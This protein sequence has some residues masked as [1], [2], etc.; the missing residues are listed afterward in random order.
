M[1]LR[2]LSTTDALITIDEIGTILSVNDDAFLLLGH[3]SDELMGRNIKYILEEE[4]AKDH[5]AFLARYKETRVARIVGMTRT[6]TSIHRDKSVLPLELQLAE[7]KTPD[8]SQYTARIRHL[9][10]D[11]RVDHDFVV[12]LWNNLIIG[13]ADQNILFEE[14]MASH[15]SLTGSKIQVTGSKGASQQ[16][17]ASGSSIQSAEED[18]ESAS[19]DQDSETS[20]DEVL[21]TG[22]KDKLRDINASDVEEPVIERIGRTLYMTFSFFALLLIAALI[23][24]NTIADPLKH[25]VFLDRLN[26]LSKVLND[27]LFVSRLM[28]YQENAKGILDRIVASPVSRNYISCSLNGTYT[29][30]TYNISLPEC[31]F[32]NKFDPIKALE[33]DALILREAQNWFSTNYID[34]RSAGDELDIVYNGNFSYFE[35]EAG[36]SAPNKFVQV[37]SYPAL[38][39]K[40]LDATDS[41]SSNAK[42]GKKI[43]E[44]A[45][46]RLG[47]FFIQANRNAMLDRLQLVQDSVFARIRTIVA[48]E[49]IAHLVIAIIFSVGAAVTFV[50][51]FIPRIREI[52]SDRILRLKLLLLVPKSV[53]WDFVYTIYRDNDDEENLNDELEDANGKGSK[54]DKDAAKQRALKLRSEDP[55]DIINDNV[56]GLYSFFGIG[57]LSMCVP[58][59]VHVAWRYSFNT[60]WSQKLDFYF[61]MLTL[62][63]YANS[64][65]WRDTGMFAPCQ[66]LDKSDTFCFSISVQTQFI[67]TFA[68][69]SFVKYRAIQ[70]DFAGVDVMDKLLYNIEQNIDIFPTC[71]GATIDV[72]I[73]PDSKYKYPAGTDMSKKYVTVPAKETRCNINF[74]TKDST[75]PGLRLPNDFASRATFGVGNYLNNV[76]QA[77]W[78][79]GQTPGYNITT[80]MPSGP[81]DVNLY[82]FVYEA[83]N[84]EG[85]AGLQAIKVLIESQLLDEYRMAQTAFNATYG[86]TLAYTLFVFLWLFN[87]CKKDL[88]SESRHNRG[89]L[90]MVPVTVIAKSR[91]VVEYIE[92]TFQELGS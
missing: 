25:F 70:K 54:D 50:F 22:I 89:I 85:A 79:L 78:V 62:Y 12:G 56:Y 18:F 59:I 14:K 73:Y 91:P 47:V 84:E 75:P 61:D 45:G 36:L 77:S 24:C 66:F 29:N 15:A 53:V 9:V 11:E 33:K 67:R 86:V 13:E 5:D 19:S 39:P 27:L 21:V 65:L 51:G 31:L 88:S 71:Q 17:I 3:D 41:L 43:N 74:Q 46:A 72:K 6:L 38:L 83:A 52:Q 32:I 49:T 10:I 16:L 57:L 55:V 76:L 20:E 23:A 82:W 92:R 1:R 87:N 8:G 69:R 30:A 26:V 81:M 63:T 34:I 35:Y 37:N 68:D 28:Y 40:V 4:I 42:S 48:S 58:L 60:Q 90:F 44:F 64:L 7:L 80:G 2:D